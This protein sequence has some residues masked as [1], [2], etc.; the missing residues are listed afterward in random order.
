LQARVLLTPELLRTSSSHLLVDLELW[1]GSLCVS[2]KPV[3]MLP[4]SKRPVAKV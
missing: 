1:L 2:S 3:L 4:Q